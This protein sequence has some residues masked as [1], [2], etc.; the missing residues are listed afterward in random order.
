MKIGVD[1][2]AFK[3]GKTGI[4]RYLRSLL[5][6]LQKIDNRNDYL[7]FECTPSG[8]PVSNPRWKKVLLHWKLPGIA[9]QL[10]KHKIDL[11]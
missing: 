9:W 8:Y 2:K 5:D 10:R 7:L 4:S 11:L 6:W 3:N 1:I